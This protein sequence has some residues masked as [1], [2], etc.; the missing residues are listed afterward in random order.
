M[1]IGEIESDR[2]ILREHKKEDLLPYHQWI[3]D[4]RVMRYVLAFPRTKSQSE[5]EISLREA[6]QAQED[7]PRSMFYLAITLK[8][9]GEYIGSG[10]GSLKRKDGLIYGMIREDWESR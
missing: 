5:S 4:E 8:R 6:I 9:S 3:S 10:S 7:D 2:L 1:R